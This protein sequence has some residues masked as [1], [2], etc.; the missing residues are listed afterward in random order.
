MSDNVCVDVQRDPTSST[1]DHGGSHSIE[2]EVMLPDENATPTEAMSRKEAIFYGFFNVFLP[3]FDVGT[4][5][6]LAIKFLKGLK[7]KSVF[8]EYDPAVYGGVSLIFPSLSFIFVARHWWQLEKPNRRNRLKTSFFLLAQL[9][10]QYRFYKLIRKG[11]NKNHPKH[12]EWRDDET[13]LQ[14]N[15]MGV[16]PFIESVPQCFWNLYLWT[17]TSC[18][19]PGRFIGWRSKE[20]SV[21]DGVMST[22]GFIT[23]VLSASYG[24]T[25][26]LRV[27]P[28]K[29]IPGSGFWKDLSFW[30]VL[31]TNLCSLVC[32]GLL[33]AIM[34]FGR[35]SMPYPLGI[36]VLLTFM[37]KLVLALSSL[38]IT[39]QFKLLDTLKLVAKFPAIVLMPV[40]TPFTFGPDGCTVDICGC[41]DVEWKYKFNMEATRHNLQLITKKRCGQEPNKLRLHPVYTALNLI[42]TGIGIFGNIFLALLMAKGLDWQLDESPEL[43]SFCG[44]LT[45]CW[46][47]VGIIIFGILA[48]ILFWVARFFTINLIH[49]EKV[50]PEPRAR[51]LDE[52]LSNPLTT[53]NKEAL[54]EDSPENPGDVPFTT[55]RFLPAACGMVLKCIKLLFLFF[56]CD[57]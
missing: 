7:C 43:E 42:L 54:P 56:S 18:I 19:G 2:S 57:I 38:L 1:A 37:P 39:T 47:R 55:I 52:L 17:V 48:S 41:T 25:N 51:D 35:T 20:T 36:F 21:F 34:L 12:K 33:M 50:N 27:G 22:V 30:L 45:P 8:G 6:W 13:V 28:L 29:I 4:D 11:T 31:L 16:E 10:P 9:W 32:Q 49:R 3:T 14:E 5:L 53:K 44:M 40:F 24:L 23:S 15:I 26:F 46:H